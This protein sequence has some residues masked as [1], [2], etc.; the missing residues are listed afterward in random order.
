M[1]TYLGGSGSDTI[2]LSGQTQDYLVYGD[3]YRTPSQSAGNNKIWG[4]SGNDTIYAGYGQDQ[5]YG[6]AGN[7][8]IY[9]DGGAG[10]TPGATSQYALLDKADTLHGDAGNDI[11]FGGGGNDYI[12]GG[13]G[14][15]ILHGGAG[16]DAISGGDGDDIISGGYGADMLRGGAGADT[17][18]YAYDPMG[19]SDAGG[20]RDII[21]DFQAGIDTLDLTGYYLS[22]GDVSLTRT[23][24]GLLVSFPA[25]SETGEILLEGVWAVQAGDIVLA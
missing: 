5:V 16:N 15:D 17:F 4:G 6:G 22:E 7:D 2:N 1:P 19:D 9:G 20:G 8:I 12:A 11:I 3:G 21:R 14:N 18:L 10:P 24:S 13:S 25:V 23:G